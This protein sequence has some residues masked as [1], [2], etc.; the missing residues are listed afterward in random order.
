MAELGSI[1]SRSISSSRTYI[2]LKPNVN[3]INVTS[4][5]I[6]FTRR[7]VPVWYG[8][9]I[10]DQNTVDTSGSISGTVTEVIGGVNAPVKR[11]VR[12]HH[13]YTGTLISSKETDPVTGEFIFTGLS[14]S[15]VYYV[16]A[17]DNLSDANTYN[18]LIFDNLTPV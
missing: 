5:G 1:L 7:L 9:N 13:R 10:V 4:R 2:Y 12:L 15:D 3:Q 8:L 14:K 16:L 6:S 11:W 17:I 18:A